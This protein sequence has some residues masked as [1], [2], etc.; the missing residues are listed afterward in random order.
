MHNSNLIIA[1]A[2]S[3]MQP[4][5]TARRV[6]RRRHESQVLAS[7][8]LRE[9]LVRHLCSRESHSGHTFCP[10]PGD[11]LREINTRRVPVLRYYTPGNPL[12]G[13]CLVLQQRR[14][15]PHLRAFSLPPCGSPVASVTREEGAWL[16][17]RI[18]A[19]PERTRKRTE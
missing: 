17:H 10:S 19:V 14:V 6:P 7:W 8:C 3:M 11:A 9:P 2:T 5:Q 4:S 15:S 16:P 1:S 18:S 12:V 13:F